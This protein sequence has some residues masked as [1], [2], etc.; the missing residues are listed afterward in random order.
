VNDEF[1]V[2]AQV[3]MTVDDPLKLRPTT[4]CMVQFEYYGGV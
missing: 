1:K 2:I 4:D 3:D